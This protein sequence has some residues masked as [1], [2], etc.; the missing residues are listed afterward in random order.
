MSN[1]TSSK[2][3]EQTLNRRKF[4]GAAGAVGAGTLLAGCAPGMTGG[5]MAM[6]KKP[7]LD[8]LDI[9]VVRVPINMHVRH[10]KSGSCD[11]VLKKTDNSDIVAT[12][13]SVEHVIALLEI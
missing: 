9:S 6:D 1:D 5:A 12:K 2:T 13:H 8:E 11:F 4:L 3:N 7:N 10:N